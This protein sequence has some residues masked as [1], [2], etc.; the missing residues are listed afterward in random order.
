MPTMASVST[1]VMAL[2]TMMAQFPISTPNTSH[3]ATPLAK[4][5]YITS[6][7]ALVSRWRMMCSACG[8]KA[9]V[10]RMA[11]RADTQS[12]MGTPLESADARSGLAQPGAVG[13]FE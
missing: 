12:S 11:A 1:S 8:T 2:E 6:E 3:S 13:A 5:T 10:V 7:M 4:A 9:A